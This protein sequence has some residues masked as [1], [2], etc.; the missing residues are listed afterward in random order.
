[1][2]SRLSEIRALDGDVLA[3]S[4]DAPEQSA[5]IVEAY[6]L[7]FPVLSDP[8]AGVIRQYGI[9]HPDGGLDGDIARPAV[10]IIDRDGRVVWRELTD[11]WRI[12]VR[13]GRILEELRKIP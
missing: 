11:N 5:E 9:L 4:V 6:G 10:F 12:R 3:V 1:L 2:Q 8:Q 7:E 13:P